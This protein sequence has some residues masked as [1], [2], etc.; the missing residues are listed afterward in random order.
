MEAAAFPENPG[1]FSANWQSRSEMS[2]RALRIIPTFLVLHQL[3][4]LC[5]FILLFNYE[6]VNVLVYLTTIYNSDSL[7]VRNDRHERQLL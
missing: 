7:T 2:P 6:R 4:W 3:H 1:T 5:Y